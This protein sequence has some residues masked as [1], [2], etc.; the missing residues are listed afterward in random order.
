MD[1]QVENGK[2]KMNSTQ[3][4]IMPWTSEISFPLHINHSL[5]GNKALSNCCSVATAHT[6]VCGSEK[7]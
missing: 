7:R 3:T 4:C 5:Q 2:K 6:V 1:Y